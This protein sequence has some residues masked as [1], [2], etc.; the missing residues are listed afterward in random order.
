MKLNNI[1]LEL[2][3]KYAPETELIPGHD[4]IWAGDYMKIAKMMTPEEQ[5]KMAQNGWFEDEEAWSH[6]C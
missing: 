2:I 5:E 3:K 6:F 1:G 4:Q